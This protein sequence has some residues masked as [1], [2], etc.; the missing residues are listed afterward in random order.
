MDQDVNE[1]TGIEADKALKSIKD[2][3]SKVDEVVGRHIE[4]SIEADFDRRTKLNDE[5]NSTLL[6]R[7]QKAAKDRKFSTID[8]NASFVEN[9]L[10]GGG[11][12]LGT[13]KR[14]HLPEKMSK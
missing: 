10:S 14:R 12:G 5:P 3:E 7:Y 11:V 6:G 1:Q 4:S 8:S 2:Y 9:Y 13:L